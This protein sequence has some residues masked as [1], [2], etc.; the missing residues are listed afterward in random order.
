MN[1]KIES[2]EKKETIIFDTGDLP[3]REIRIGKWEELSY[4]LF[5]K[6]EGKYS[7][8]FFLEEWSTLH[9]AGIATW[10]NMVLEMSVF[11]EWSETDASLQLLGLATDHSIIE[12]DGIGNVSA[13]CENVKLRID[14]SNI[15]LGNGAKVKGR[16]VLEVATDSIEWGHSCRIHRISG[17]AL[18][19]LETRGIDASTAEWMLLEAE[20]KR[21]ISVIGK[22][23]EGVKEEVLERIVKK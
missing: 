18:F 14:Q 22:K 19:Y 13:W 16:P 21:H 11:V 2:I 1:Q 20:I 7:I 23:W 4:L 15:L 5:P 12:L 9:G 17:E 3:T 6:N 10:A 8:H